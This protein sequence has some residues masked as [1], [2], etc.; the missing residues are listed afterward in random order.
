ML[1]CI[2]PVLGY[3]MKAFFILGF[4]NYENSKEITEKEKRRQE[5]RRC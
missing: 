4:L 2:T 3:N 1:L 5:E